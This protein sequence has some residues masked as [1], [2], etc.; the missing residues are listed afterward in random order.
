VISGRS[1]PDLDLPS[2]HPGLLDSAPEASLQQHRGYNPS[3]DLYQPAHSFLLPSKHLKAGSA[4]AA[5]RTD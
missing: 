3:T 2:E 4:S 5:F 1:G